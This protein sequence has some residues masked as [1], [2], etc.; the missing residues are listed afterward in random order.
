M[1]AEEKLV[2]DVYA[3]LMRYQSAARDELA[4]RNGLSSE[5]DDYLTFELRHIHTGPISEIYVKPLAEMVTQ[6]TDDVLNVKPNYLSAGGGPA[7]AYYEAEWITTASD[8]EEPDFTVG[9]DRLR[10]I[11]KPGTRDDDDLDRPI[12][13]VRPRVGM[14]VGQVLLQRGERFTDAEKYTSYEVTV[15]LDGKQRTYRALVFHHVKNAW[16]LKENERANGGNTSAR[17]ASAELLDNVLQ[18]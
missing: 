5:P 10:R 11:L 7:H 9:K 17:Q 14:T 2:R 16:D 13:P 12:D 1:S 6:R 4:A 8:S 18:R 15:H 3:R